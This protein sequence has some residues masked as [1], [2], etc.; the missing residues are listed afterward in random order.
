MIRQKQKIEKLLSILKEHTDFV[1]AKELSD[2]LQVSEKTI[3]RLIQETND[4]YFPNKIVTTKKGSGLKLNRKVLP[5]QQIREE[6]TYTPASRQARILERLLLIAPKKLLIYD[7][8]QEFYVSDSVVFKDKQEIQKLIDTYGLKI[9]T[10]SGAIFIEGNE[11]NIRR[12][13]ADLI[14]AFDIIDIDNL[15]LSIHSDKINYQI[16]KFVQKEISLM[17]QHL[18]AKL[19]YPYNVNIFSHLYIM[20]ERIKKGSRNPSYFMSIRNERN[21]DKALLTESQRVIRDISD[22]LGQKINTIEINYLYQYLYSS[23]F[24]LSFQQQKIRFSKRVIDITTFYFKQMDMMKTKK[25]NKQSP[26]F[27]DLANH[28]SPLLRRLDNKIRIKNNMLSEIKDN[29]GRI[30]Q[31]TKQVSQKM[32]QRYG[33]PTVNEDEIGFLT[34]YFARFQEMEIRPIRTLIMCSSG[35]GTS[36][37]LKSKIEKLFPD[38]EIVNVISYQDAASVEKNYPIID[39]LVT[40]VDLNTEN[41]FN[42]VLIS[43]MMNKE[44]QSKIVQKIEEI[45]YG[46]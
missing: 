3:Y 25:I 44:D 12:A 19:P 23:R 29:Y 38:I 22:Y 20:I 5:E 34:L 6:E 28:I 2:Y 35:I 21:F 10:R 37:L 36:E 11:E 46:R 40:T 31:E 18:D 14:P 1:T 4:V 43:A 42:K 13:I 17:E 8:S 41:R 15:A 30:F 16:A 9:A 33:F 24:Q 7:L 27:I 39:L 45:N 26:V 32:S